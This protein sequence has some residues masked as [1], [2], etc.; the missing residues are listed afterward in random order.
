M[1]RSHRPAHAGFTLVELL[2]TLVVLAVLVRLAAPS[3]ASAFLT[4]RLASYSNDFVASTQFARSEAMKRGVP[5]TL[6][7]SSDGATCT[8]TTTWAQGW[9]VGCPANAAT[10][11]MCAAGGGAMLVLQKRTALT[12]DYHF[13]SDTGGY[14]IAFPASGVG[15]TQLNMTL[16]RSTPEPGNQER[17]IVVAATGRAVVATTRNGACP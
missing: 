3:F 14:N 11:A 4:N 2:V 12:A 10:D 17:Q 6:C 5:I 1:R 9:I 15:A 16:C 13:T 7:A 8:S